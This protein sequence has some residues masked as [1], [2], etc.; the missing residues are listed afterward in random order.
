MVVLAPPR[1]PNSLS[2]SSPLTS[3]TLV[4]LVCAVCILVSFGSSVFSLNP[5]GIVNPTSILPS[6]NGTCISAPASFTYVLY[7][8]GPCDSSLPPMSPSN[9]KPPS[10]AFWLV[11]LVYVNPVTGLA[12]LGASG[13]RY[14]V[15]VPAKPLAASITPPSALFST[16]SSSSSPSAICI[17]ITLKGMSSGMVASSALPICPISSIILRPIFASCLILINFSK[18]IY[19]TTSAG[20]TNSPSLNCAGISSLTSSCVA[21]GGTSL[22]DTG[23]FV[24]PSSLSPPSWNSSICF[25]ILPP[26][27]FPV[28]LALALFISFLTC[29]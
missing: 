17:S 8:S 21:P 9:V 7:S 13:A 10:S 25:A 22:P 12:K 4:V 1:S 3:S 24:P 5:S 28:I 11:G 14:G 16:S 2:L 29:S 18:P 19:L 26:L 27:A 20:N 6:L 23:S 15:V